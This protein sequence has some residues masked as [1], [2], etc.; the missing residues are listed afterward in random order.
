MTPASAQGAFG[1]ASWLASDLDAR[2]SIAEH[3]AALDAVQS[4]VEERHSNLPPKATRAPRCTVTDRSIV[5]RMSLQVEERLRAASEALGA[6]KVHSP[7]TA[8]FH[9]RFE[10]GVNETLLGAFPCAL[11]FMGGL[12]QGVLY[13]SSGHLCF[14]TALFPA[15]NT[16][17]ALS[18]VLAAER[19]RDPVFHLIPNSLR[20][21]LDAEQALTFASFH[22]AAQRD[23][24]MALVLRCLRSTSRAA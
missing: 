1:D 18:R 9:T 19:C 24:C 23:E 3:A 22:P 7:R 4:L 20:L 10:V 6:T 17:L 2:Q 13:V 11:H 5:L 8:N 12:R 15:A 21:Q 14:E 16:K